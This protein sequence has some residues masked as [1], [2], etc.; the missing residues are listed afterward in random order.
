MPCIRGL[1]PA[2]RSTF[3]NH[4]EP[5][6]DGAHDLRQVVEHPRTRERV[7]AHP[8]A[9]VARRPRAHRL[10]EAGARR[11]L[12]LHRDRVLQVPAQHVGLARRL[13]QPCPDLLDVR[14]EE[15]DHALGP[16]RPLVQ[17]RRRADR[18]RLVEVAG[19]LHD[20]WS[21]VW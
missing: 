15:V 19:E 5:V 20:A 17:R 14:R 8:D 21:P 7:H 6:A 16:H 11:R 10:D 12:V 13:R 2:I 18:E 4:V 1:A 3:I 9:R